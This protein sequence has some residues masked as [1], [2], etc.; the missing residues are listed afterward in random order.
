MK[1]VGRVGRLLSS[2]VFGFHNERSLCSS[3]IS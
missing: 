1:L 3:N 2:G